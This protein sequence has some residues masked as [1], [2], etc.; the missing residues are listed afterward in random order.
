MKRGFL[1]KTGLLIAAAL[2]AGMGANAQQTGEDAALNLSL[3]QALEIALSE[4][5]TIKVAEQQIEVKKISKN[6]A[7]QALLPSA[8][9]SGSVQYTLLAPVMNLNGMEFKMGADE[10][11]TW[12]G[13]FQVS[14]PLFAPT[15]YATMNL[16][17]RAQSWIWSIRLPRPTIR[18][19]WLKTAMMFSA[20]V[21][22]RLRR[23]LMWSSHSMGWAEPASMTR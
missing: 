1:R 4:N 10:T 19:F 17:K 2:V 13:Q 20:R 8:D 7:W 12:N 15:V 5:P 23:T 14:L 6:E 11:S 22:N 21:W 16:T 18:L 3:A 9:F